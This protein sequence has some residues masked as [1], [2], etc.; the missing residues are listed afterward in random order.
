MCSGISLYWHPWKLA[1]D[2]GFLPLL[3]YEFLSNLFSLFSYSIKWDDWLHRPLTSFPAFISHGHQGGALNSLLL[4]IHREELPK[5]IIPG[6]ALISLLINEFGSPFLCRHQPNP[7][8][9][10][11]SILLCLRFS[12]T[13]LCWQSLLFSNSDY[14]WVSKFN[15]EV[16]CKCIFTFCRD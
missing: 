6:L 2:P 15:S 16:K 11:S 13:D 8:K 9:H 7:K 5:R 14:D 1:S 10:T 4:R 3:H 12:S